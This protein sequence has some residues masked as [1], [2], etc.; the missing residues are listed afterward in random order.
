MKKALSISL[1][2]AVWVA[3]FGWNPFSSYRDVS[4]II[5]DGYTTFETGAYRQPNGVYVVRALTRMPN[6]KAEMVKWWFA[7][8]MQTS[9]HYQRWHPR[10]HV[11]MDWDNKTSGRIIGAS[12][13]VHEYNGDDLSKLRIEFVD[14]R[15]YLDSAEPGPDRFL[16]CAKAGF[17]EEPLN[18][19][20]M[21]HIVRN[22]DWGAEMRS[23]FWLGHVEAR[24]EDGRGNT[25]VD[26][27][28]N[29]TLARHVSI[30]E[31]FAVDLMT[32]ALEEMGYL[33]DFL[34]QLHGHE[35]SPSE[36]RARSTRENGEN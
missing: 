18:V 13:L 34:P 17:L 2:V 21:C 9:E 19:S 33:A 29:T 32:H 36:H 35:N 27:F 8:Y 4:G 16:I 23:V 31:Q 22:T 28:G 6:V 11:W 30:D 26:W 24:R 14:P 3:L 1:V 12:H 7:D 20:T 15:N 25:L 5:S 10:D